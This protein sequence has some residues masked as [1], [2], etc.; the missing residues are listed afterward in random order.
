[1]LE[2]YFILSHPDDITQKRK[3]KKEEEEEEGPVS[4]R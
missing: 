4:R 2:H 3:R 1:L